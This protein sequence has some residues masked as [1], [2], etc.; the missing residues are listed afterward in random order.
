MSDVKIPTNVL[1]NIEFIENTYE[2]AGV[3]FSDGFQK[4]AIQNATGARKSN[5]KW[6]GWHCDFS[7]VENSHGLF[8]V[9]E[10]SGT[11]GLTGKNLSAKE[12]EYYGDQPGGILPEEKLARFSSLYNSGG[13][14]AGG[15]L[16]GVGKTVY[17][18]ASQNKTFYYDSL[19]EDGTYVANHNRMAN[20]ND[21]A[22]EGD[23][24]RKHIYD[25]PDK[26]AKQYPMFIKHRQRATALTN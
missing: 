21:G 11:T 1:K 24:A 20:I 8:L 18:I 14:A 23:E 12:I 16:Y 6:D 9:V 4:D 10:D 5:S 13:N 22:F 15:G 3:E 19:R 17:L 2:T 25:A 26:S 7:L